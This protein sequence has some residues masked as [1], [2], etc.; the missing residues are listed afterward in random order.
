MIFFFLIY[1]LNKMRPLCLSKRAAFSFCKSERP[2]RERQSRH[3]MRYARFSS[4]EKKES[5]RRRGRSRRCLWGSR[6]SAY[7][8]AS[9]AAAFSAHKSTVS[10]ACVTLF[11]MRAHAAFFGKSGNWQKNSTK[12]RPS[13][14]S[15]STRSSIASVP[16]RLFYVFYAVKTRTIPKKIAAKSKRTKKEYGKISRTLFCLNVLIRNYA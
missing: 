2:P 15:R 4:S 14:H 8:A 10:H 9:A 6:L 13:A 5:R 7:L 11:S 3:V 16:L 1:Y 12:Q